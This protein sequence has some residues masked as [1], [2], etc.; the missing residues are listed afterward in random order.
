MKYNKE[1][2]KQLLGQ[3]NTIDKAYKIVKQNTGE[4]FNLFQILGL[5]T[6]EV[7]TH[8]KFLAELL[9]P[10]G[11]HLQGDIFLKL[12][13][14]YLN[15]IRFDKDEEDPTSLENNQIELNSENAKVYVEKHIGRKNDDEGGRVDI[16]IEDNGKNLICIENKIYAGE[17]EKQMQRYANYAKKFK[18][19]HLF[20]LTLWGNDT[21]TNGDE[22]VYPISYKT[23]I[24]E[25]LEL[26]KKEA[27][28]L[29]ILRETIGQYINLI[30]KLTHQTT[31]KHMEKEI[32][33]LILRN[34]SE[35]RQIYQ[36]YEKAL[37]S[38]FN[39]I[40]TELEKKIKSHLVN[41]EWEIA[42][43]DK[44]YSSKDRGMIWVRPKFF[45]NNWIIGIE[46]I[47]PLFPRHN[48]G[49]RI[50][51]GVRGENGRREYFDSLDENQKNENHKGLLWN[52]YIYIKDFK[53]QEARV[54]NDIL[55]ALLH[56][57]DYTEDFINHLFV[58]FKNYFDDHSKS[59][60][61]IVNKHKLDLQDFQKN[62]LENFENINPLSVYKF[63]DSRITKDSFKKVKNIWIYD[64]K[65]NTCLVVEFKDNFKFDFIIEDKQCFIQLIN[66]DNTP[67]KDKIL[68]EITPTNLLKDGRYERK[69]EG[70][71]IDDVINNLKK[72]IHIIDD[73][74]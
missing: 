33:E 62:S 71:T 27:V 58:E 35:S 1:S 51:V 25:W 7:K 42:F 12:F 39:F 13:I 48:F 21:S 59:L 28:N 34:L 30:K 6:A 36:N 52:D 54:D 72:T 45:N 53:E 17:Q 63:L 50:F 55:L 57:N 73:I 14:D 8:S 19:S 66:L 56:R 23:H 31:N 41:T 44:I 46:D 49:H 24:I 29:P 26:C 69:I 10:N 2:L 65:E 61:Q 32:Q 16:A 11:S 5:E 15:N 70:N 9:N 20:F 64:H 60:I 74:I 18:R 4:D 38:K 67:F 68:Q 3:V 47:N 37:C 22:I 40:L 43:I